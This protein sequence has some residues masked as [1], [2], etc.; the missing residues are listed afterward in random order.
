RHWQALPEEQLCFP[1]L[2]PEHFYRVYLLA[3]ER[4]KGSVDPLGTPEWELGRP[5]AGELEIGP[6][7]GGKRGQYVKLKARVF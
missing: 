4:D 5:Q 2:S 1:G 6:T 3:E 7:L